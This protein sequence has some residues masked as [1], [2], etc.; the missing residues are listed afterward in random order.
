MA[1]KRLRLTPANANSCPGN[2]AAGIAAFTCIL[3]VLA[4]RFPPKAVPLEAVFIVI[5]QATREPPQ[6]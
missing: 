2:Q 6:A 4:L 1:V 5:P 3:T